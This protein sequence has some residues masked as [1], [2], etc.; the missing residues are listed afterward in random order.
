MVV[1]KLMS[2]IWVG[3]KK[4]ED[5]KEE[6]ENNR[7]KLIYIRFYISDNETMWKIYIDL[8]FFARIKQ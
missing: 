7:V 2:Q 6:S 3:K 5:E 1:I 4:E 8:K